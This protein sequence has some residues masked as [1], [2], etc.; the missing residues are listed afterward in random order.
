V[1]SLKHAQ[2]SVLTD[3]PLSG[4]SGLSM[5]AAIAQGRARAALAANIPERKI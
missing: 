1:R 5:Q 3:K 2:I 4:L